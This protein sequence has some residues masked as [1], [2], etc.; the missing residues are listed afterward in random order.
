MRCSTERERGAKSVELSALW[1]A[2][3]GHRTDGL[4]SWLEHLLDMQEVTGSSPVSPTN[5]H[6][7]AQ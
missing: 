1:S 2:A 7:H 3:R 4:L 5:H 6:V